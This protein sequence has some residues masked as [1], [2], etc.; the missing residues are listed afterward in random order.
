MPNLKKYYNNKDLNLPNLEPLVKFYCWRKA[1]ESFWFQARLD[2]AF[3]SIIFWKNPFHK[4][5]H[6]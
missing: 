6:L 1:Y 3:N 5:Q 2:I 4:V